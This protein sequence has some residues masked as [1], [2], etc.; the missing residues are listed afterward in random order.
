MLVSMMKIGQICFRKLCTVSYFTQT[1]PMVYSA[2]KGSRAVFYFPH[3]TNR[4][5]VKQDIIIHILLASF[6]IYDNVPH[7]Q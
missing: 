1:L 4:S 5:K 6:K 2:A 3:S 7:V